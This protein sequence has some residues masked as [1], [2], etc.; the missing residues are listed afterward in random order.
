MSTGGSGKGRPKGSPNVQA[1]VDV[2]LSRCP[3]C[4]STRRS[5]YLDRQVQQHSGV[6]SDGTHYNR[7]VRRRTRCL[8]CAQMRIDRTL[9]LELEP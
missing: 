1:V 2:E 6:R 4:G 5:E 7:I 3:T 9:E 8:D